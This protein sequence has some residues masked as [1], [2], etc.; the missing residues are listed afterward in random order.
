MP[1]LHPPEQHCRQIITFLREFASRA[2]E[3]T[4]RAWASYVLT[5]LCLKIKDVNSGRIEGAA[6]A[7]IGGLP[8]MAELMA[9]AT[10]CASWIL[11]LILQHNHEAAHRSLVGRTV[12]N[13]IKFFEGGVVSSEPGGPG[14]R[15]FAT[16]LESEAR[17]R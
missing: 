7:Q 17:E 14:P 11:P 15:S 8:S 13:L 1:L 16:A 2:V 5:Q 6:D 10:D 12:S 9:N 3:S 4:T